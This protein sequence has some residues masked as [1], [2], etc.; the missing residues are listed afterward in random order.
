MKTLLDS[1]SPH[2]SVERGGLDCHHPLHREVFP[3]AA[4]F[5]CA[6]EQRGGGQS[7]T[8]N[9]CWIWLDSSD[10]KQLLFP[11]LLRN[12]ISHLS[13]WNNCLVHFPSPIC[14]ILGNNYKPHRAF[15][16]LPVVKS[17]TSK[18]LGRRVCPQY[19]L[20]EGSSHTGCF[21]GAIRKFPMLNCLQESQRHSFTGVI[22]EL[23]QL[24]LTAAVSMSAWVTSSSR[25][26]F[27]ETCCPTPTLIC[28]ASDSSIHPFAGLAL[29]VFPMAICRM[30]RSR[31]SANCPAGF[32]LSL[33]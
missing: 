26:N 11:Q 17:W 8:G 3:P 18:V 33:L 28:V 16:G 14:L 30:P 13:C 27:D 19:L 5:P 15:P 24:S 12:Q 1:L 7:S 9:A 10:L 6:D 22:Q 31:G 29:A 32:C 21:H 2:P 25:Y 4:R 23:F 20:Q